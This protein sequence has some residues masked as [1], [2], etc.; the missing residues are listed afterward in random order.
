[1]YTG[2]HTR[3]SPR[4]GFSGVYG[5]QRDRR[6]RLL[7]GS[8]PTEIAKEERGPEGVQRAQDQVRHAPQDAELHVPAGELN[9]ISSFLRD[10]NGWVLT[11]S[12]FAVLLIALLETFGVTRIKRGR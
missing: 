10:V 8:R 9:G 2:T 3:V 12:V 5:R 11:V 6:Q 1:M 4:F 7:R